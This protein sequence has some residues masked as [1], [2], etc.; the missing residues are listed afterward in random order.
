MFTPTAFQLRIG[1]GHF[2]ISFIDDKV[3]IGATGISHPDKFKQ[4][5]LQ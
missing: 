3:L 4:C 2:S 5:L 1:K